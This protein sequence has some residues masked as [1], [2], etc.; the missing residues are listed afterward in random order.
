MRN[1]A[2]S[3][4]REN[5]IQNSWLKSLLHPDFLRLIQCDLENNTQYTSSL[6]WYLFYSG[7]YTDAANQL[8]LHRNTLIYRINKIQEL[9]HFDMDN[10]N[11]KELFLLSYLLY[12]YDTTG[13]TANPE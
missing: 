6:Y 9:I 12:P 13:I 11:D 5:L 8:N 10:I 7:N 1:A 4:L 3:C 2:I